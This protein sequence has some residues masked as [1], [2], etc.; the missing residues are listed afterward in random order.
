MLHDSVLASHVGSILIVE[1]NQTNALILRSMLGKNGYSSLVASDGREGVEMMRTH[2][3]RLVL[4]DLQMPRLD[5]FSAASE[6]LAGGD[7]PPIVAVTASVA[8][9][10]REACLA[11]G[12]ADVISKPIMI[13]ELLETVRRLMPLPDA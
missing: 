7:A 6:I 1:D 8:E 4:M 3:P 12:F 10:V 5:G 13:E 9:R 2:R 11:A